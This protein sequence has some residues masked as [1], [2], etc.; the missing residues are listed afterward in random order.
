MTTTFQYAIEH[1]LT[2]GFAP[3]ISPLTALSL[4][5]RYDLRV[6]V[7]TGIWH[8]GTTQWA[9]R[10]FDQVYVCDIDP[11]WVNHALA[12]FGSTP[13]VHVYCGDSRDF[14]LRLLPT[15]AIPALIYLDAHYITDKHSA[16]SPDDCPL[17]G[18]LEV[19]AKAPVEHIVVIDDARLILNRDPEYLS[20]P[21]LEDVKRA[22]GHYDVKHEGR[23]LIA[24]PRA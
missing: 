14:L 18:E 2:D 5:A 3:S 19:I 9:A 11:R 21:T 13:R 24:R 4:R 12:R 17:L 7:E 22:L 15:L 20:W 1:G 23:A 16:G 8:G 6:F 10:H